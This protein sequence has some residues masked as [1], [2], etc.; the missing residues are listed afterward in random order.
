MFSA[1]DIST[2]HK[3]T[4]RILAKSI[5]FSPEEY[6]QTKLQLFST[7]ADKSKFKCELCVKML[8]TGKLINHIKYF[9]NFSNFFLIDSFTTTAPNLYFHDNTLTLKS[10]ENS[11]T[12]CS[13]TKCIILR[14]TT[15]QDEYNCAKCNVVYADSGAHLLFQH[16]MLR[17]REASCDLED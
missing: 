11:P 7:A 13:S 12:D 17:C 10:K 9:H 8:K 5:T 14:Q 6:H 4:H 3:K 2:H 15:T 16:G 1:E